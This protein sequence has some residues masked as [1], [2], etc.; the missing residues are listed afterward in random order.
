V[1]GDVHVGQCPALW[2]D[3]DGIGIK[4]RAGQPFNPED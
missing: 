4:P 2:G 3:A 1:N